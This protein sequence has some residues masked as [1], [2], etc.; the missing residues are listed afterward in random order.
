MEE[1][2]CAQLYDS[3]FG[4]A[5]AKRGVARVGRWMLLHATQAGQ[6]RN[7]DGEQR[8]TMAQYFV[9]K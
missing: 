2:R 7:S 8:V 9:R 1:R 5:R 3:R 4:K 6:L